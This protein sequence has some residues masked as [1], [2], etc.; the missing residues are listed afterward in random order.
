MLTTLAGLRREILQASAAYPL[1]IFHGFG[2]LPP[3][4]FPFSKVSLQGH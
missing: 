3:R 1:N 2:T 4:I